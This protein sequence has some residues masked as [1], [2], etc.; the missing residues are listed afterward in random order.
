MKQAIALIAAA[1]IS[2]PALA[3]GDREQGVLAGIVGT[4]ILQNIHRDSQ[5]TI[6]NPQPV[7]VPG[8][9]IV[10]QPPV[11]VHQ[12]PVVYAPAPQPQVILQNTGIVCP[13]G[14]APF[15]NQRTDRYGRSYYV[16]DGCR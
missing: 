12:P 13:Q 3:W 9:V 5:R 2:T 16:F 14:L 4:L 15:F 10:Q 8:P 7:Y 11:V 6:P 1:A